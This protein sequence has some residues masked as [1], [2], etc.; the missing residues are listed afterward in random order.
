MPLRGAPDSRDEEVEV[1]SFMEK[2][3]RSL[4]PTVHDESNWLISYADMMTLLCGFFIMLFSMCKLDTPL[5]DSF[6]EVLVKQFGGEYSSPTKEMAMYATQ[7]IQELGIE[8]TSTITSDPQ[9]ISIV[10]ESTIFF[11][12]LSAVITQQGQWVLNKLIGAILKKSK[13]TAK[14][15][16]V[17][18]EGHSDGRPVVS[19]NYASNWELSG[20]RAIAVIRLFLEHG[21]SP[22]HLA[23]IAYGDTHPVVPPRDANGLLNEAAMAKNRRVVLRILEPNVDSIPMADGSPAKNAH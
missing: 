13:E 5:Y 7:I 18:V 22:D 1:R 17:I 19:G 12:T 21:F 20:S 15:Y 2:D 16:R 6:K 10:F 11:D 23:A 9:G 4:E 8:S 14:S 3:T